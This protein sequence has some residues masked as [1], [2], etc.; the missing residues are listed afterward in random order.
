MI[1]VSSVSTNKQKGS[2]SESQ[3]MKKMLWSHFDILTKKTKKHTHTH[4]MKWNF[5]ILP[6]IPEYKKK[7]YIYL[8]RFF[9]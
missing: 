8:M 6:K 7:I 4:M 9:T 1:V 2:K 5:E 3:T